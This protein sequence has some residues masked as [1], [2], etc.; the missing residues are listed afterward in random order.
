MKID[1]SILEGGGA[2]LRNAVALAALHKTPIE[3]FNIRANRSKPGLRNQHTKVIETICAISNG[4]TEGVFTGSSTIWFYPGE[5]QGGEYTV[6]I[7]TAGSLSL[8]LQAVIPVAA[9]CSEPVKLL[10]KGGTDVRWSPPIDYIRY[11]Y[12]PMMKNLGLDITM[13]VGRRGHYPKG[14][15][16]ISCDIEPIIRMKPIQFQFDE[17][18]KPQ[19][20]CGKVHAVRLPCDIADRMTKAAIDVIESNG[21]KI[22]VIEEECPEPKYD[23]HCGPGTGIT[24]WSCNN[25]GTILAGDGLGEKGIPAEKV[26]R[27][28]AESIIEQI[29]IGRPIDYHL[30]DQLI[31]W[32]SMSDFP[33]VIDT[34]KITLHTLTNIK[35]VELLTQAEFTVEG[36]EGEPGI[37]YCEP[38]YIPK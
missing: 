34:S 32:M 23:V 14:G 16:T 10:L 20:I 28:A 11:V 26:G 37:I 24:L 2:I 36:K 35:I 33:S 22:G 12:I 29:K 25:F 31:I 13:C 4:K 19:R 15:G 30:A 18:F 7:G 8:L 6:D 1:G 17:P 21:F 27:T 38:N 5:L 9:K 3:I